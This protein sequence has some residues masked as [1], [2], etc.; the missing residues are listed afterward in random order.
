[1]FPVSVCLRIESKRFV[2]EETQRKR[3][4]DDSVD[5]M[6]EAAA[7]ENY[8]AISQN[9]FSV[10][11]GIIDLNNGGLPPSLRIVTKALVRARR[12]PIYRQEGLI[13]LKTKKPPGF[14]RPAAFVSDSFLS[15]ANPRETNVGSSI[16]AVVA[17]P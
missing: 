3:L 9:A 7:D 8:W 14:V 5:R 12:S 4:Q 1:M 10:T 17:S 6:E 15:Y 2:E 13:A 16:D 11:R